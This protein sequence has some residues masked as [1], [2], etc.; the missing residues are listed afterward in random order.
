[1]DSYDE[2]IPYEFI[3]RLCKKHGIEFDAYSPTNS[4]VDVVRKL[5]NKESCSCL[6]RTVLERSIYRTV[7]YCNN[8]GK[9]F[10]TQK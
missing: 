5:T 1:M 7:K 3:K 10:R 6:D 4:L 2:P 9:F 8:C